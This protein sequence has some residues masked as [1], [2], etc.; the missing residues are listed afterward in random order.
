MWVFEETVDGRKLTEIINNDHVNVKYLPG[1]QL[2]K[3][4][5]SIKI[6]TCQHKGFYT[7]FQHLFTFFLLK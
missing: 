3:S 1:I 5:V 2:P 6:K 7:C 4:V